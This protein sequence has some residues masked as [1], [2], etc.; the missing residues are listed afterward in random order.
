MPPLT[1]ILKLALMPLEGEGEGGGRDLTFGEV[2]RLV[3]SKFLCR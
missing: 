1:Q 3:A 2:L